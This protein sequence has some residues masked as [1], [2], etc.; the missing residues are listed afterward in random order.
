M[1]E[2][3]R[4]KA[5]IKLISGTPLSRELAKHRILL[6]KEDNVDARGCGMSITLVNGKRIVEP[7]D[8]MEKLHQWL[9]ERNVAA[10]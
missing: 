1:S 6:C 4:L 5:R 2:R 7:A 10:A 9:D 3:E 8:L